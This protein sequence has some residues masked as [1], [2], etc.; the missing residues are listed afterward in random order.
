MEKPCVAH[1]GKEKAWEKEKC[2][3]QSH[4]RCGGDL[5][6]V[7]PEALWPSC[8]WFTFSPGCQVEA[9]AGPHLPWE[10]WPGSPGRGREGEGLAEVAPLPQ[11]GPGLASWRSQ[12]TQPSADRAAVR[13][14]TAHKPLCSHLCHSLWGR[15][16][17]LLC[18]QHETMGLMPRRF[19]N[20]TLV[21]SD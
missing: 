15:D 14:P 20:S 1:P 2:D 7:C 4:C 8:P 16:A 5:G 18:T 11:G 10:A 12:D 17:S 19:S 3:F 13:S 21:Q 6:H 9:S